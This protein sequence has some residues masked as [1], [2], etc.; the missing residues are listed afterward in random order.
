MPGMLP[1]QGS[2]FIEE[3]V[4]A[5]AFSRGDLLILDSASSLSGH[6][7][8]GVQS[9]AYGIALAASVDSINDRVPVSVLGFDTIY[10]S[11][12][13][14]GSTFTVG[15]KFDVIVDANGRSI[16]NNSQLTPRVVVVRPQAGPPY[17][18][19]KNQSVESRVMV[20]F[21]SQPRSVSSVVLAG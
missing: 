11:A 13:T 19:V 10:L 1:A 16:V 8:A 15:E 18:G 9:V 2:D 6:N 12:C 4:P 7:P 17:G 3:G 5:S 14:P 21:L 20:K